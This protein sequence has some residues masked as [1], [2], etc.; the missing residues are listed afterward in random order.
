[1][2]LK[3]MH[4][5]SSATPTQAAVGLFFENGRFDL[6]LR[7]LRKALYTQ[8]LRYTQ[9]I[10]EYFPADTEVTSPQGG[11]VLWL[12]LNKKVNAFDLFQ[13]ALEHHISV[14]PGQIFSTD[15]RF[16]NFIRISFGMPFT[17]EIDMSLKT[18]GLLVKKKIST[19]KWQ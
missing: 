10:T 8:C 5:V 15:A 16:D 6:H 19:G 13:E 1:M 3:F 7:H 12:K 11:Y 4:T 14:A 17:R 9:A 18:L 2:K